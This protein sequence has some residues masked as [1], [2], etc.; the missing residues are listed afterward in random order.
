MRKRHR[1]HTRRAG[2]LSPLAIAG[3]CVAAVILLTVLAGNLLTLWLDDETYDRLTRGEQEEGPAEEVYKTNLPNV[4]AYPHSLGDDPTRVLDYSAASISINKPD[5]SL[6]Y[7]SEVSRLQ[8]LA[9]KESVPLAEKMRELLLYTSYVSGVFYP[10]AFSYESEDARFAASA[11]EGALLREFAR[12]GARDVILAG[13]PLE[14]ISSDALLTYV[15]TVKTALGENAAVGVAVPLSLAQS[16]NGWVLLNKLL[17]VADFCALDVT[18]ELGAEAGAQT[19]IELLN[20]ADYFLTQY[21]MRLML[22]EEQTDLIG[23]VEL[24]TVSDY[25]I[26]TKFPDVSGG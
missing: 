16:E 8:G 1:Y 14:S 13:L 4:N 12:S 19:P 17:E 25:Q 22:S 10:Q 26:V 18:E 15:K 2:A 5:G 23:E 21:D 6:Q 9:G 3:I 7:V 11:A 20:V 24:R